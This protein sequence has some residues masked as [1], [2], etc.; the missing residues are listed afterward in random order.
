MP[1]LSIALTPVQEVWRPTLQRVAASEGGSGVVAARSSLPRVLPP[2]GAADKA[3]VAASV[4]AVIP[5]STVEVTLVAPSSTVAVEETRESELPIS[6]G[7]GL[8][9]LSLSSEPKAPEGSVARTELGRPA[10]SHANVV[11]EIPFDNEANTM[12]EPVVLSRE[13]V[14]VWSEAGPSGGSSEG[15]LEWPFPED[16]SKEIRKVSSHKSYFFRAEHARM[17]ELERRAEFVCHESQIRAAEEAVARAEG[18]CAAERAT[19]T[20][21]GLEAAK[22]RH[23]E[24][25]A[26]LR[27]S[28]ANTEAVLQE[29]LAAL[30]PERA[31]LERAQKAL[32]AEQRARSEADQEVLVLQ[33]QVMGMED[34]V[35]KFVDL[36]PELGEKVKALERDLETSK[37]SFSRNAK[38]LAKSHEE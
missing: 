21:L 15:D 37:A 19:A 38:E 26:G 16:P 32:E 34:P 20:E 11:V 28:L 31:T 8:H 13:L 25:E 9:D 36:P 1:G 29:A 35:S 3:V 14:V 24:I 30:E 27:T 12:A 6:P 22:A 17:A 7:G 4:L 5:V 33:S 10:A 18:Q 2:G 23:E